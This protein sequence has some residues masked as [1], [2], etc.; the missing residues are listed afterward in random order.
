MNKNNTT[1]SNNNNQD[2]STQQEIVDQTTQTVVQDGGIAQLEEQIKELVKTIDTVEDEKLEIQNKMVK[3]LADY[4]N[5][6][7]SIANRVES[8][9]GQMKRNVAS[10]LIEIVD[11]LKFGNEAAQ[12]LNLQPEAALWLEGLLGTLKKMEK[13]LGELGIVLIEVNI[14]DQFDSSIHE[15]ISIVEGEVDNKIAQVIQFGYKMGD[16]TIRPAR[17]IVSKSKV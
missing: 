14:G 8:R 1:N 3:A 13:A 16:F 10:S 12:K 4:Q 5:L 9:L 17:V 7:R 2:V 11:D 6:E 15:A